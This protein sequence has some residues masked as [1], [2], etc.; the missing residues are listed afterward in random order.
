M[1]VRARAR[2]CV[3]VKVSVSVVTACAGGYEGGGEGGGVTQ[4]LCLLQMPKKLMDKILAGQ[5]SMAT[6]M[7]R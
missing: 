3:R 2:A 1:W 5:I 7:V 4:V 6:A